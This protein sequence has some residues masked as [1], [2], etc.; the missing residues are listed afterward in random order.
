[1]A[2]VPAAVPRR[3]RGDRA[4]ERLVTVWEQFRD[5][6]NNAS[7]DWGDWRTNPAL[8]PNIISDAVRERE[9]LRKALILDY[10]ARLEKDG[11]L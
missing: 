7:T 8:I 2:V 6:L 4:G 5:V 9:A 10:M 11:E 1:V 3:V